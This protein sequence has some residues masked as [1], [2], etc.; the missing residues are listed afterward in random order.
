[1][2]SLLLAASFFVGIHLVIS[3]TGL[4]DRLIE[5]VGPG[6]YRGLFSLA[7]LAGI[8]WLCVAYGDAPRIPLWSSFPG[9]RALALIV[10][11]IAIGFVMLG[12]TTP[13]AT[14]VGGEA[15][16]ARAQGPVGVQRIT[17]HPFLWGVALW[18]AIHLVVNGDVASVLLFGSL[19]GL[20]VAGTASIDR[21]RRRALGAAWDGFAAVT[22]NLPFQAIAQGRNHLHLGEHR[23]W[24]WLTVLLAYGLLAALHPLLFG[25]RVLPF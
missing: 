20:A 17:R 23:P 4:R 13:S 1:M 24:Q 10:M 7:S 22:S 18:A 15:V 19:G 9:C 14:S 5:R 25:A 12:L 21:K 8:V 6:P 11:L 3:G 16:L 2:L